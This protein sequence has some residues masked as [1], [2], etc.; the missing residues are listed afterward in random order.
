M[1]KAC[2]IILVSAFLS[3]IPSI[4]VLASNEVGNPKLSENVAKEMIEAVH[5]ADDAFNENDIE[6]YLTY[7]TDD[8]IH[9]NV[10]RSPGNKDE[11]GKRVASFFESFPGIRNYQ[12][13][14][15]PFENYLVFDE[16]T[17]EIPVPKKDRTI[18]IFHMDIVEMK[19]NK[20]KV[21]TTF[22]DGASMKVALGLIEP[23][24]PLPKSATTATIP[25]PQPTGLV[26]LKA[27]DEFQ[28]RWNKHDLSSIAEMLDS[29]AEIL[30][31]P[32]L[33][34]VDRNAY[35]GWQE[36]FFTAFPDISMTTVRCYGGKD[37]AVSEIRLK[38]TNSGPYIGNP[39]TGKKIELKAGYLT[40]FDTKG[41]IT[42]LKLYI[43]SMVIMKQLGLEPVKTTTKQ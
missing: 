21:K 4:E 33:D 20:L 1:K 37:W 14:L 38:G 15:L 9:D 13:N 18:K 11:F 41:L 3:I 27:Q 35:I 12:K 10:S 36:L 5:K 6:K 30:V 29:N 28:A 43:D 42:S 23:P 24:L 25:N 16:C 31:S 8:F 34:P 26:P 17:F 39:S 32:I 22:G 2:V 19:G 40:R 7:F